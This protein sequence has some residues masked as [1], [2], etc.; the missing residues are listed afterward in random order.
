MDKKSEESV[1]GA[2]QNFRDLT[3]KKILILQYGYFFDRLNPKI[4]F[5]RSF[6]YV[7]HCFFIF[8]IGFSTVLLGGQTQNSLQDVRKALEINDIQKAHDLLAPESLVKNIA[9]QPPETITM[10]FELC[11]KAQDVQGLSALFQKTQEKKE[12]LFT[13]S[14]LETIAWA[15]I[16]HSASSYHPKIRFEALLAAAMSNDAKGVMLISAFLNDP[17]EKVAKFAQEIACHFPD[18][19]IQKHAMKL[20]KTGS[21]VEKVAAAKIL[22][23]HKM[24]GIE[25]E[26]RKL[27][28]DEEFS[29]EDLRQVSSYLA[30]VVDDLTEEQLLFFVLD[31]KAALRMF[32]I[33]YAIQRPSQMSIE[34]ILPL[35]DDPNIFIQKETLV[36]LALWQQL[37]GEEALEEI[38]DIDSYLSSPNVHLASNAACVMLLS[39]DVSFQETASSWFA[40]TIVHTSSEEALIA[41]SRL[42]KTGKN[43][44][45]ILKE[46]LYE[47]NL[48]P[49]CKL[50][51]AIS[52]LEKREEI[53]YAN[54]IVKYFP[55]KQLLSEESDSIFSWIGK[56]SIEHDPLNPRLPESA[57]LLLRLQFLALRSYANLPIEKSECERI[58]YERS[59]GVSATAIGFMFS[60]IEP[61]LEKMFEE[62]LLHHIEEIRIQAAYLY[63]MICKSEKAACIIA[64]EYEKASKE[65]KE[66]LLPAYGII[67]IQITKPF[68]TPLLFDASPSIRTKAAGAVISSLYV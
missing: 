4:R 1:L 65:G 48:D 36:A 55:I 52:L 45:P 50:N 3:I 26:L 24:P 33:E 53:S 38:D 30:A 22:S 40:D 64:K 43:G 60:E 23:T 8:F 35:L 58:L 9:K 56:T 15:N 62:L 41:T 27:L 6:E 11:C 42:L 49:I 13:D 14:L 68:L 61:S 25:V 29:E 63:A 19:R 59:Y 17:Q 51:I 32:A 57:D 5:F 39:E 10:L 66:I 54:Q 28:E 31:K 2:S 16:F 47:E 12:I 7:L 44:V 46:L 18:E 67:P 34:A 21:S 20:L 37:L